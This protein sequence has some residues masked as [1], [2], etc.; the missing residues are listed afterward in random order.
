MGGDKECKKGW[1]GGGS[2]VGK[3]DWNESDCCI[4]EHAWE[5][6]GGE[7]QR[8]YNKADSAAAQYTCCQRQRRSQFGGWR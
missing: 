1:A 8:T 3:D 2:G 4:R 6:R 7:Q 5:T